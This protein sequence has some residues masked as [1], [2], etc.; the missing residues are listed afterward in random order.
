MSEGNNSGS[1]N[2]GQGFTTSLFGFTREEV[3]RYVEQLSQTHK[4]ETDGLAQR[5]AAAEEQVQK[6][7]EEKENENRRA[8]DFETKSSE[9]E[10]RVTQL[11]STL[12]ALQKER[13]EA[14]TAQE[15]LRVQTEEMQSKLAQSL[16]EL[17]G[18][19]QREQQVGTALLHA[20]RT[21]QS[22]VE[23]AVAE[24]EAKKK[25]LSTDA[26]QMGE[27]LSALREELATVEDRIESA[28]AS[29]RG[30]TK[31]IKTAVQSTDSRIQLLQGEKGRGELPQTGVATQ[32]TEPVVIEL[33]PAQNIVFP[34]PEQTPQPHSEPS[35]DA[36]PPPVSPTASSE[37]ESGHSAFENAN[38]RLQ[39][40]LL[41]N[42]QRFLSDAEKEQKLSGKG[43]SKPENPDKI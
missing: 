13:D 18:A 29:M 21:A 12:E 7:L 3:L 41:G 6:A 16:E 28:F 31:E 4:E 34:T 37:K 42:I 35:G 33:K 10:N 14:F 30:V 1:H 27:K 5:L 8:G 36:T 39:D 15:T 22:I 25:A 40:I 38:R 19:R 2:L 9:L 11:Q 17:T 24:A 43:E 32:R 23:E 26:A 20:Q